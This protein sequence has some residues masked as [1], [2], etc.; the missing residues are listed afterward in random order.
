MS[1]TGRSGTTGR[2][3]P[4]RTVI[5]EPATP[6]LRATGSFLARL[7][8]IFTRRQ[9]SHLHRVPRTGGV[10]V[11]ANHIS[12]AD[13]IALSHFLV[14]AGRWPHFLAKASLFRLPVVGPVLRGC[15][16][17][18]VERG[19][20]TAAGSLAAAVTAVEAGRCVV[21]YPEGTITR[22]PDLW[23][24]QGKTGA[25]RIS[26]AT[27]APVI[28]VAQWGAQ[29]ILWGRRLGVPRLL[30]RKT[31][32]VSAGEP[33]PLDELRSR[34]LSTETL[35]AATDLIMGTL[36]DQVAELRREAPPSIRFDLTDG[37]A[38]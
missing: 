1:A 12:N 22:D 8:R 10:I 33:I 20:R 17:I 38:R 21:V 18:P 9:W 29:E 24:M 15:G 35:R 27:G 28:P 11:V 37:G 3:A 26:L 36:T 5:T 14:Y 25:A 19:T 2:L 30:P 32:I 7:M 31:M 23:P 13:P 34:P 6:L 16:Q 4:L